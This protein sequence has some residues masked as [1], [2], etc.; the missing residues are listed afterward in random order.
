[1]APNAGL[2]TVGRAPQSTIKP[3][4]P[5][6]PFIRLSRKC[7]TQGFLVSGVA[8]G[9]QITQQLPAAPGFVRALMVTVTASGGTGGA[10]TYQAD[11]PF[12][13]LTNIQFKDVNGT[14]ILQLDGYSLYLVNLFSGQVANGG[15]QNP[16]TQAVFSSGT[17]NG[18]FAYRLIVPFELNRT[19]YCSLPAANQNTPMQVI[20]NVAVTSAAGPIFIVA[21]ATL[22][23]TFAVQVNQ[24]FWSM[25]QNDMTISPPDPGA[26]HQWTLASGG[27][28]PTT[29]ANMK[30]QAPPLG[31]WLSAIFGVVRDATASPGPRRVNAL[32]PT[33]LSLWLDT[34]QIMSNELYNERQQKILG[35]FFTTLGVDSAQPLA[36]GTLGSQTQLTNGVVVYTWRDDVQEEV[37][38]ADTFDELLQ[39]TP[40]TRLEIGGTW[41]TITTGPGTLQFIQGMLYPAGAGIPYTHLAQ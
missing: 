3:N 22:A 14:T 4:L 7:Q 16:S 12:S 10:A 38:A 20:I 39:T 26:S 36:A 30:V 13:S 34:V 23:P 1:M 15:A 8:G 32:P 19:G 25:V 29:G 40:A 31:S 2:Q 17:A 11:A 27:Q 6:A 24:L 21:P 33:D 28:N 35:N 9:A 5:G 41:G 37:S 18:N